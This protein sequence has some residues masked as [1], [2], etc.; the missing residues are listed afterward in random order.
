MTDWY[1]IKRILTWVNW[2]EKQIYPAG[3]KP[4]ANTI[5]YFPLKEDTY[6]YSWN[7]RNLSNIWVTFVNN[8]GWATIPV[9][10]FNWSSRAYIYWTTQLNTGYTI[11]LWMKWDNGWFI[12]DLRNDNQYGQGVYLIVE[13]SLIKT[14]Q[15]IAAS[16]EEEYN[17]SKDNNWDN[18]IWTWT[19]SVWTI[20]FN[21]TQVKQATI[22]NSINTSASY[23]SLWSRYSWN[24]SNWTWYISNFIVENTPWSSTEV[25][26]YYNLTKWNYGL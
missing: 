16:S 12:Y 25:S 14:R 1:K 10:Y 19:G 23:L 15:Q 3:W 7:S 5:A 4:W 9:W 6:D 11:S 24:T 2:E 8:I 13:N 18:W 17:R 20:Y 26:D 22:N 21:W